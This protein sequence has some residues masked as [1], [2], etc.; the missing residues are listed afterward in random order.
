MT[1]CE[2]AFGL[3]RAAVELGRALQTFAGALDEL[4]GHLKSSTL[5]RVEATMPTLVRVARAWHA[6]R[7]SVTF[8]ERLGNDRIGYLEEQVRV[9]R[10]CDPYA[11]GLTARIRRRRL[12]A[13]LR[14]YREAMGR[15]APD[16]RA[17]G[18]REA[19]ARDRVR[20]LQRR[21]QEARRAE[22]A[23][24]AEEAWRRI[25]EAQLAASDPTKTGSSA[26]LWRA[27]RGLGPAANQHKFT[28]AKVAFVLVCLSLGLPPDP[29]GLLAAGAGAFV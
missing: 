15:C 21:V 18:D 6:A 28:L 13:R 5:D 27:L 25:E 2:L 9:R 3:S 19:V 10:W 17:L 29:V 12:S 11:L 1:G 24:Q 20:E 7:Q 14:E 8:Y 4:D 16:L 26:R 22:D 23:R